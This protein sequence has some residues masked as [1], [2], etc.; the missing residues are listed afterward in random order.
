MLSRR[1]FLTLP[2]AVALGSTK[3][4]SIE[5]VDRALKGADV[6]RPPFSV[7]HHFSDEKERAEKHAASTLDFHREF[8]TD[9][10]KVM[11]DYPY[12]APPG[13]WYELRVDEDPFPEQIRALELIRTGLDGSAHF[14]ETIFN[15]WNVAEKLSSKEAVLKLKAEQPRALLDALE[16]IAESEAKHARKALA[17]GA[18]GI[19]FAIANAQTGIM[20]QADYKKFSEPFDRL[21]LDGASGAPL[22]TLHLH[23]DKVSLDY[24]AKGWPAAAINYSAHGTG[25]GLGQLRAKYPGLIMGGIDEQNFR[26]L[27]SEDMQRQEQMAR[28]GAGKK[29]L[30]APGCSVPNDS[31]SEEILRLTKVAGA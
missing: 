9:L 3:L 10:V 7:W 27:S 16:A 8:R 21:V 29:F 15:P 24:F 2:A 17:A 1:A 14:L 31:S 23:G 25:V 4:S 5:R 26:K 11:S 13:K 18:S 20:S 12:P 30:L 28:S 19:F 6:D 22:N